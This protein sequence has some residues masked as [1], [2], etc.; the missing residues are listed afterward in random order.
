MGIVVQLLAQPL[1]CH[2][3]Q[4][5]IAQVSGVPDALEQRSA[6]EHVPRVQG[7]LGEQ[8]ELCRREREIVSL[9]FN[10]VALEVDHEIAHANEMVRVAAAIGGRPAAA[11]EQRG[12]SAPRARGRRR[13]W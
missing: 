7:E 13:A 4:A 3:D 10:P 11:A 5:R 1:D 9:A 8:L 12:E 2:V 6:G